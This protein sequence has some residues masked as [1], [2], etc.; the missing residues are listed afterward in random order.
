LALAI[1]KAKRGQS[2]NITVTAT[3]EGLTT[4]TTT[5]NLK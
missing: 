3:S 5:I 2:G 1:V 4:A